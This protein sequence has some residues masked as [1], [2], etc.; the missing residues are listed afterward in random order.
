MRLP[1]VNFPPNLNNLPRCKCIAEPGENLTGLSLF[2]YFKFCFSVGH[3]HET[4]QHYQSHYY[5]DQG[6]NHGYLERAI[7]RSRKLY[8]FLARK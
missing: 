3:D 1:T 8:L 7:I 6:W 5:P 4:Y 2:S